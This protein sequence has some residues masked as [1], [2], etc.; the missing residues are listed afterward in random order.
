MSSQLK[1]ETEE[2]YLARNFNIPITF[3]KQSHKTLKKEVVTK[4]PYTTKKIFLDH[5]TEVAKYRKEQDWWNKSI[6]SSSYLPMDPF[7][8]ILKSPYPFNGKERQTN[9]MMESINTF[10]KP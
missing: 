5:I 3:L 2:P 4:Q 8:S 7:L 1:S 6:S 10:Q 9:E